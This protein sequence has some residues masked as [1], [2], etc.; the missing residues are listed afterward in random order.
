[1]KNY[2]EILGVSP[3]SSLEEIK[4]Q[5]RRK[6]FLIHPDKSN[7]DTKDEFIELYE[8]FV[9]LK[10]IKKRD[11]YDKNLNSNITPSKDYYDDL[12]IIKQ[13]GEKYSKDFNEF[14]K[15]VILMIFLELLFK[16]NSLLFASLLLMFFG[17]WTVI[18]GI[19][20]LD[21]IY[22]LIGVLLLTTGIY[23]GKI[24]INSIIEDA[25]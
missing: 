6:A 3:Q 2:Y 15:E 5:F 7:K 24:R 10:D 8:A 18:K 1:M 9:I 22:S 19:G 13:K 16:S 4:K 25:R 23:L 14:N 20:N 12:K 11:Q 21:L 17:L